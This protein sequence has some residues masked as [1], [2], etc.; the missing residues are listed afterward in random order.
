M[1]DL[2]FKSFEI[3]E[4]KADDD[5]NLTISGYGAIF[6]NIDSYGDIIERGAFASTIVK[7]GERIAFCYQH[8]TW[9]P[10]GKILEL[11][12]DDKGLYLKVQ[13]SGAE[14]DIQT[15]VKEGI[16]KEMSIGYRIL[17]AR[18]EI[19]E[20]KDIRM[21]EDIELFEI[22]L[23]TIAAN[24]LAIITGMKSEERKDFLTAEFDRLLAIIKNEN[25]NYEIRKLKTLVFSD[26]NEVAPKE[27]P[28]MK[29]DN[30]IVFNSDFFTNKLNF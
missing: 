21:L 25:I 15:K 9:N 27:E 29:A 30:S 5:G 18:N 19:R 17:E 2:E 20:G 7:R 8:D 12:E 10:I 22:S 16:L 28:L 24:P 23:V 26:F 6:G 14:K 11:R 3:T 4:T 1:K 13:L